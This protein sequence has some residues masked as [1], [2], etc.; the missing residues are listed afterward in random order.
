MAVLTVTTLCPAI[1]APAVTRPWYALTDMGWDTADTV[2]CCCCVPEM[3]PE[4]PG[5]ADIWFVIARATHMTL[6]VLCPPTPPALVA[7]I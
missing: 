2:C 1:A 6:P 5:A 4:D 7:T 3:T